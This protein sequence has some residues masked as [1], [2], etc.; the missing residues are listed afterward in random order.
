VS[1]DASGEYVT[2]APRSAKRTAQNRD[3]P[4]AECVQRFE[5]DPPECFWNVAHHPAAASMARGHTRQTGHATRV[6]VTEVT[7]YETAPLCLT[8]DGDEQVPLVGA[9]GG[10][11]APC[12]DCVIVGVPR[13]E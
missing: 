13:S 1:F 4:S 3:L 2:D 6:T 9:K 11:F 12:P 5:T 7:L 10:Q 8:C